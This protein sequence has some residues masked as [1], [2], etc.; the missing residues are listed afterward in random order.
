MAR[1]W[2]EVND[3]SGGQYSVNKNIKFKPSVVRSDLF[4]Y[5][6]AYTF[7]KRTITVEGSNNL[8]IIN[9]IMRFLQL[10]QR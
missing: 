9:D 4:G 6:D 8:R 3:L 2:I 7:V 10:L 5:S 1:K